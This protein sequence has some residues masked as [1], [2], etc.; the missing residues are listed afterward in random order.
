LKVEPIDEE[1]INPPK[2]VTTTE[3]NTLTMMKEENDMAG[4][5]QNPGCSVKLDRPFIY[6]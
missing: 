6:L 4:T 3:I 1:V 2:Q 5:Y